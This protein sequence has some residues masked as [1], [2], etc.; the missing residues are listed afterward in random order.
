MQMGVQTHQHPVNCPIVNAA[1]VVMTIY[2]I[3]RKSY[4][5][6]PQ[7]LSCVSASMHPCDL[8]STG[9]KGIPTL[10]KILCGVYYQSHSCSG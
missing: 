6:L 3:T 4:F 9:L 1:E 8:F 7:Y 2:H 5:L 10:I